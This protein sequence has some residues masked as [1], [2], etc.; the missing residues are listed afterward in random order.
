MRLYIN[1][2]NCMTKCNLK[3]IIIKSYTTIN[4]YRKYDIK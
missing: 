4:F 1:F 3:G 2:Y